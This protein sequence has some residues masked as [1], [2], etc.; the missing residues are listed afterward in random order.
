MGYV[1][2]IAKPEIALTYLTR[3]LESMENSIEKDSFSGLIREGKLVKTNNRD[4]N[5]TETNKTHVC[6]RVRC[7]IFLRRAKRC[8]CRSITVLS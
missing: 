3:S 5:L 1:Y 4:A 7:E 8:R 2:R 6:L